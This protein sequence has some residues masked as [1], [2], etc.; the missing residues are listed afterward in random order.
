MSN[1]DR[2]S[3]PIST[4]WSD[5]LPDNIARRS[6][7]ASAPTSTNAGRRKNNF[8]ASL[9]AMGNIRSQ[10]S[11]VNM[12]RRDRTAWQIVSQQLTLQLEQ[13]HRSEL[14][15]R[16]R[17][18]IL[19]DEEHKDH[20]TVLIDKAHDVKV[21]STNIEGK[22]LYFLPKKHELTSS[23]WFGISRNRTRK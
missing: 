17:R 22:S 3:R 6:A 19:L 5:L 7:S 18:S 13:K 14:A 15:A 2:K 8:R 16:R 1:V 4:S 21:P 9:R 11:P 12:I 20:V 10:A 23:S